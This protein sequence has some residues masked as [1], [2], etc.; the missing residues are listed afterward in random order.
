V[1]G[2]KVLEQD[3]RVPRD[4]E[5]RGYCQFVTSNPYMVEHKSGDEGKRIAYCGDSM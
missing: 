2:Y 5:E 1:L 3:E 4:S